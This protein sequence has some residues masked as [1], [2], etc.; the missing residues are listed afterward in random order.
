MIGDH[1]MGK[2]LDFRVGG[3]RFGKLPGVDVDLVGGNDDGGNLSKDASR[4]QPL[5]HKESPASAVRNVAP[6]PISH[7]KDTTIKA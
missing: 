7:E 5:A 4:T 6:Q 2:S 1:P 3:F